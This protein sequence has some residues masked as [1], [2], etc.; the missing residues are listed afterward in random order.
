MNLSTIMILAPFLL[1]LE[2][3]FAG[4]EIALLSADRVRL[5]ALAD[6]GVSGAKLA[7]E[8]M[9]KPERVLSTTLVMTAISVITLSAI[10]SLYFDSLAID[11]GHVLSIAAVSPLVVVFGELI[12]K[13]IAQRY[14]THLAPILSYLVTGVYFLLYPITR[15]FAAYSFRLS[16]MVH[17]LEEILAG[18]KQNHRDELMSLIEAGRKDSE[19]SATEKR[20]IKRIF[21]FKDSE[22]KHALIPLVRVEA[23]EENSTVQH[24]LERIGAH[25]HSRMPVYSGRIDN[26]VGLLEFSDLFNSDRLDHSIRKFL[27]PIKYVAETHL[28]DDLIKL[29]R[30]ESLELVAVVDEYGG[31][32]GILT[33]EDIVEEIVGDIQDEFDHETTEYKQL[34]RSSWVVQA[35]MEIMALNEKMGLEL[36]EGDYETLGGFLLQQFSKLPEEGDLIFFDTPAGSFRFEVRKCTPRQIQSVHVM[37]V[38]PPESLSET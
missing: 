21:D 8:L 3:I 31:A 15:F 14:S 7:L 28:L 36:P 18:R 10:V 32:I 29:M 19:I 27:R 22:A 30:E 11:G 23:I 9:E 34:D 4:S 25:R 26:I 1:L 24:A 12:P 17:P 33:F 16:R 37:R 38:E 13:T 2:G 35:R 20:M 6:G 5:R